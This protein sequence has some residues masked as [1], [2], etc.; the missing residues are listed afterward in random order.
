M[1]LRSKRA[2]ERICLFCLS[3]MVGCFA[4]ASARP[5]VFPA[6]EWVVSAPEAQGLDGAKLRE[7]VR[8]LE[9]NAGRDGVKELVIVRNG[10]LIHKGE[11]IDKVHGVWSMTKSFTSTVLGLLV[12][13]GKVQVTTKAKEYVPATA[14]DFGDVTLEHF[15]TMTSGYRAVGDEPRG[16]YT[17]GPSLTPFEPGKP[18]FAPGEKYAY[19]DSA[20]NQFG[21]VLTQIACEKIEDLFKSKIADAIGMDRSQW[22][23]GEFGKVDGLIVNGGSGNSGKHMFISA[24]QM[25]RFGHLFL[26]RGMWDGKRLLSEEWVDT[27]TRNHVAADLPW[28][29]SQ[30]NI[31]GM[32]VYGYNWWVNGVMT[33]GKRLW[34]GAPVGTYA[35]SGHNNNKMFVIPEWKM[36]IVRLGLDQADGKIGSEVW[37]RFLRKVGESITGAAGPLRVSAKNPRYFA[38]DA[39]KV[40]YLTGSHTWNNLVDMGKSDPPQAFDYDGCLDWMQKLNHN[41]I[42]LWT[43]EPVTW[44]TK[45]NQ[46]DAINNASPQPWPR[47][48]PGK[49]LDGKSRFDLSKFDDRYF[50]RLR[51]RL[52]EANRRGIYVSIMLFEGWAMQF[53]PGAWQRHPFNGPNNVNALDGDANGDGKGLEIHELVDEK[54]RTVQEAYVRKVID[55]VNDLNNVLYEISNE[56]HPA[57]TQWQYHMIRYIKEYEKSKAKQHP[58]GMTFQYKGGSNK[59]LFDSPADWVSP[60]NEGGYRDNPPAADGRKVVLL[61]TDHLWGIGGNQAWVW[62]AFCRGHNPLFMDPYDG[63][64]LGE[65]FDA[66]WEPIRRSL[67]YTHRY[68]EKMDLARTAPRSDLASTR[69]C[70]AQ[71]PKEYLVYRPAGTADSFTL[72][73]KAGTYD[74]EWFDPS[75]GAII[76]RDRLKVADGEKVFKPGVGGDVVLYLRLGG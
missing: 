64:I 2:G 6:A 26:N 68:A 71:P 56:N 10:Y 28:G 66:R 29:H 76:K 27:A 11:S 62:K 73:L 19:W 31:Y 3:L 67:G 47:T 4:S 59:V 22:D 7:A 9:D 58:V 20:M 34:P 43:W 38:D 72:K 14:E 41:F 51:R 63:L 24:R 16:G 1:G 5:M 23:W 65:R 57:S 15:A 30:S 8:Y 52:E 70:L 35:A 48:G 33:N 53:S 50:K 42:R 55:T 49:A 25:A 32:G 61:D 17:H 44:N 45:N 54:V 13:E 36:V 12:D 46:R 69:Y 21:N 37:G 40:V 75:K 60:N 39:G 74:L 18:L